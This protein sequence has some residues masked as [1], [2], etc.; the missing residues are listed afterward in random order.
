MCAALKRAR[1]RSRPAAPSARARASSVSSACS[2]SARARGITG[3]HQE[4]GLAVLHRFG[5]AARGGRHDGP[6][7]GHGVE[8]ARAQALH[9]RREAEHRE[10]GK[11]PVQVRCGSPAKITLRDR[12]SA[13]ACASSAGRSSPSPAIT[14]ATRGSRSR[15]RAVASIKVAWSLWPVRAATLPTTGLPS[16]T[17]RAA[18]ASRPP[19]IGGRSGTPS[20][21]R[22]IRASG[23]PSPRRRSAMARLTAITRSQAR[24]LT[25][26]G[27]ERRRKSTRRVAMTRARERASLRATSPA[28]TAWGSW[29]C[30]TSGR[31]SRRA[32]ARPRIPK[33]PRSP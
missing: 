12:P 5:D 13:R 8:Q 23:R 2:A 9:V 11:Q 22:R 24:Y 15:S 26:D 27:R 25:R 14:T 10:G 1:K 29:S 3:R 20:Y 17:P 28:D 21:T 33:G 6:A 31:V 4:P 7:E 19:P 16:G 30:I 18:R 32:R